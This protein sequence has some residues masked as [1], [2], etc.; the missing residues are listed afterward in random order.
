[1]VTSDCMD[2]KEG[3][4]LLE[5]EINKYYSKRAHGT[6]HQRGNSENTSPEERLGQAEE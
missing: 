3:G 5:G 6:Y 2:F 1:M 4:G